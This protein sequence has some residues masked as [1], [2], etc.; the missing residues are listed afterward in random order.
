[1]GGRSK[2]AGSRIEWWDIYEWISRGKTKS[3]KYIIK[4]INLTGKIK[5]ATP[6][7]DG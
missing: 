6:V 2:R 7:K 3:E 1:M 4:S 5:N